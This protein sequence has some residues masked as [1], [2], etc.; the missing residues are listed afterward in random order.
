M[1]LP[2]YKPRGWTPLQT[3]TQLRTSDPSYADMR[4]GYAGRLDPLAEGVL[5]ILIDESNDDRQQYERLDK[6]YS[7][8]LC[9][10]LAS[11]SHDL[12]GRLTQKPVSVCP[13][14]DQLDDVLNRLHGRIDQPYPAFSAAR[15]RGKPLYWWAR[16]N[17]LSE[18]QIPSKEVSIRSIRRVNTRTLALAQIAQTADTLIA[19]VEG[20]FRQDEIRADWQRLQSQY[21]YLPICEI[22]FQLDCSTGTYVRG[23][24][25]SIGGALGTGAVCSQIIRTSVGSYDLAAC[26]TLSTRQ[27]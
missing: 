19:A 15:V 17:R 20:D 13:L 12:M 2:V 11:D 25:E 24:A 8:R 5:L 9:I 6:T 14:N 18:I 10:G 23:L 3:I 26:H 16:Q 22:E 1:I 27:L 21:P 7:F 4:M